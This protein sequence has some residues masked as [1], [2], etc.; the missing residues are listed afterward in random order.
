MQRWHIIRGDV[1]TVLVLA[2]M[3]DRLARWLWPH[4][5]ADVAEHR[6][7]EHMG[8][9]KAEHI[10]ADIVGGDAQQLGLF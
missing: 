2:S 9:L 5:W 7:R 4:Y 3:L 10:K 1:R 8:S 6:I